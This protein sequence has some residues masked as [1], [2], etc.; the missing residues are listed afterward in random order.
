[1]QLQ[2]N[3]GW[4]EGSDADYVDVAND[5]DIID[6]A[7]A[8]YGEARGETEEGMSAVGHT[9]KTRADLAGR[10]IGDVV[11]G[12]TKKGYGQYSSPT[13]PTRTR[14][15]SPMHRATT[16]AGGLAPCRSHAASWMAP[17]KT[18]FPAP[19]TTT[20]RARQSPAGPTP[21]TRSARSAATS[22]IRDRPAR[23]KASSRWRRI[24][25]IASRRS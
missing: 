5:Q 12:A 20:P 1:M 8:I 9:I 22:S 13:P 2:G 4:M 21:S 19:P 3:N 18:R 10:S 6:M 24:V 16:R 11:Y 14:S 17:L 15:A 25:D 7:T 23:S